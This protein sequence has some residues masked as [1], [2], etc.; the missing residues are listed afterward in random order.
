MNTRINNY[1]MYI[2]KLIDWLLFVSTTVLLNTKYFISK[3][4]ANMPLIT[5]QV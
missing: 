4:C 2:I 5:V 1:L 3:N